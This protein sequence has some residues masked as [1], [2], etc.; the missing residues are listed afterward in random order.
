MKIILTADLTRTGGPTVDPDA[1][2]EALVDRIEYGEVHVGRSTYD[3]T[4]SWEIGNED[5]HEPA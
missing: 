4:G 5:D 3:V 1:V 2:A